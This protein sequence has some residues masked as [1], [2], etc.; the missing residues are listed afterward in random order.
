MSAARYYLI[1]YAAR[2]DG[3]AVQGGILSGEEGIKDIV[4]FNVCPLTLGIETTGGVM[5]KPHPPQHCCPNQEVSH[6]C[7]FLPSLICRN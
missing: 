5:T 6:V 2:C 7:L 4:L 1:L 3:A